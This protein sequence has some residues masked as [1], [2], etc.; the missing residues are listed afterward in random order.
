[1]NNPFMKNIVAQGVSSGSDKVE[2]PAISEEAMLEEAIKNSLEDL[3]ISSGSLNSSKANVGDHLTKATS[4]SFDKSEAYFKSLIENPSRVTFNRATISHQ[5][6]Y[7]LSN[8]CIEFDTD[9]EDFRL[10]LLRYVIERKNLINYWNFK[11]NYV[12]YPAKNEDEL[13]DVLSLLNLPALELH[14]EFAKYVYQS[15]KD[16]IS[17]SSIDPIE[18]FIFLCNR[19]GLAH[20]NP[21][22]RNVGIEDAMKIKALLNGYCQANS[23]TMRFSGFVSENLYY[24]EVKVERLNSFSFTETSVATNKKEAEEGAAFKALCNAALSGV[25]SFVSS[26]GHLFF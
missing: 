8:L 13:A 21:R 18:R 26:K 11:S 14:N 12:K 24:A 9:D 5:V 17:L 16:L 15:S 1:M 10:K 23:C 25:A 20:N 6:N 22:Y 2:P 4:R 19:F 7:I 3:S